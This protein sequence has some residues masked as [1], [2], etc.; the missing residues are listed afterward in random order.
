MARSFLLIPITSAFA[1]L[2]VIPAVLLEFKSFLS[3]LV[4]QFIYILGYIA[5]ARVH[6]RNL[7]R[8][9]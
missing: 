4:L 9:Q 8:A 6:C 3:F 2:L 5:W 1:L 7:V